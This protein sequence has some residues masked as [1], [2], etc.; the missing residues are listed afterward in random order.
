MIRV[1]VNQLKY[2]EYQ[3]F[4]KILDDL[5]KVIHFLKGLGLHPYNIYFGKLLCNQR[6]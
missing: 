5:Q 1:K 6:G 2:T 3:Q 4:K